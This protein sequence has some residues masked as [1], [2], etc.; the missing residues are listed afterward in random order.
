MWLCCTV[1]EI[2][3][4]RKENEN[5]GKAENAGNIPPSSNKEILGDFIMYFIHHF[6][7]CR[8]SDSIVSENAGIEARDCIN[9]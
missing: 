9:F 6:F 5:T 3:F 2:A 4:Y 7:I 1:V 8:P